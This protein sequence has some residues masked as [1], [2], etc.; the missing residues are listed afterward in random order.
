MKNVYLSFFLVL[1][2]GA[3]M[4]QKEIEYIS[5]PT[6]QHE[7]YSINVANIFSREDYCKLRLEVANKSDGYL[8]LD[9]SKVGF[10]YENIGTYYPPKGKTEIIAPGNSFC[11]KNR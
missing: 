8:A 6:I 11:Y 9:L 7:L 4:A 3:L 1:F 10:V 2:A 5:P